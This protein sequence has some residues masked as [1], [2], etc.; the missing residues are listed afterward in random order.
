MSNSVK[1][2][3]SKINSTR[4]SPKLK[5]MYEV[6]AYIRRINYCLPTESSYNASLLTEYAALNY[7]PGLTGI[8]I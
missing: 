6:R 1:H 3:K 5:L 7:F 4:A 2:P 8:S